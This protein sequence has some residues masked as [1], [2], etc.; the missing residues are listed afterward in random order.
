V[1]VCVYIHTYI[2]RWEDWRASKDGERARP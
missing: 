2:H 1:C